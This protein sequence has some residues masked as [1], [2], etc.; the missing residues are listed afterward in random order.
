MRI[1]R[2]LK[3]CATELFLFS[4]VIL[5]TATQRRLPFRHA[6]TSATRRPQGYYYHHYPAL[7]ASIYLYIP[8]IIKVQEYTYNILY[9][10]SIY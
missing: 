5:Y 7:N 1:L 3:Y 4:R 2:P 6:H 10:K 8:I 9:R